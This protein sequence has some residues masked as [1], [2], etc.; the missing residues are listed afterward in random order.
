MR[1]KVSDLVEGCILEEDVMGKSKFPLVAKNT[2]IDQLHIEVLQSFLI[3]EVHVSLVLVNGDP[4]SVVPVLDKMSDKTKQ[5]N[6]ELVSRD[7]NSAFTSAYLKA[8]SLYKKQFIQWQSGS[9]VDVVAVR[10]LLLPLL[11]FID[12]NTSLVSTLHHYST[13]EDYLYHH[14]VST[15]IIAGAIGKK[16]GLDKGT[17][18][19]LSIAGALADCGMAKIS[20]I[21]LVKN[22]ALNRS[23]YDEVKKHTAYSYSLLKD[24]SFLKT[25]MKVAIFQHHERVDGSGYPVGERGQ[26]IHLY[27]QIIAVSDVYHAM[28]SE[29]IY[30]SKK[31]P[32]K[33]LEMLSQDFF[34]EYD[35][36]VL[37]N[38]INLIC[39]F[40]PGTTVR[41]SNGE[42]AQIMFTKANDPLRPL[43][44]LKD[45]DEYI[46]LEKS[47]ALYIESV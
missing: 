9:P 38:L 37:S 11:E 40:T 46:D 24:T 17:Y 15:G 10:S 22:K 36:A 6:E 20:N 14:G 34:G 29:R 32:Y 8:V 19:Q 39:S 13:K 30:R 21:I 33:V 28:T 23:E 47:R 18:V 42:Y 12:S 26:R 5:L 43:I 31:S 44:R 1:V 45:R 35:A 4:F 2:V 41:L 3:E 16:L 25:E 7:T 27:A